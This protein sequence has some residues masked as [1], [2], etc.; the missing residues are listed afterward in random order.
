MK[1]SLFIVFVIYTFGIDAGTF[2]APLRRIKGEVINVS[3]KI[4][5]FIL[6]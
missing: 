3:I 5:A 2:R 1:L 6:V 4:S